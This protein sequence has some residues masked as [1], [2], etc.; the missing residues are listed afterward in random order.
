MRPSVV[1]P[2]HYRNGDKSLQDLNIFKKAL[3]G[4]PIEVRL[5]NWYPAS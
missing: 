5:R 4:S 3:S 2:Y 1:Y